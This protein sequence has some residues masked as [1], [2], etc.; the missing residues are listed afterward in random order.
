MSSPRQPKA[1][2]QKDPPKAKLIEHQRKILDAALEK[3]AA[4]NLGERAPDLLLKQLLSVS[5]VRGGFEFE[6]AR[7]TVLSE[8]RLKALG[9]ILDR[10]I[11][12]HARL[13]EL[14]D[15]VPC[16]SISECA[17]DQGDSAVG[18]H[19]GA[20]RGISALVVWAEMR[21]SIETLRTSNRREPPGLDSLGGV[22]TFLVEGGHAGPN[23]LSYEEVAMLRLE[24]RGRPLPFSAQSIRSATEAVRKAHAAHGRPRRH[25]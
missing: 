20:L 24:A 23:T 14:V 3:F 21:T 12:D 11:D 6:Q 17:E 25:R 16:T 4:R 5:E 8:R 18:L 13:H 9:K 7:R 15:E 10:A 1:K 19:A 2:K 22:V